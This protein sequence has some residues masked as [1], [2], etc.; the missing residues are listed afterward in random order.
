MLRRL[1]ALR[2]REGKTQQD[3]A[4]LLGVDRTTYAKYESGANEPNIATLKQLSAHFNVSIDYLLDN[5]DD[6]QATMPLDAL[7]PHA[8][9]PIADLSEA[10]KEKIQDFAR[11]LISQRKK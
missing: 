6:E 7:A 9:I 4:D 3:M 11:F 10:D 1:R 5:T 2:N 8:D